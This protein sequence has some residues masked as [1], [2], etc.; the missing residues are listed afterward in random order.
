MRKILLTVAGLLAANVTAA[1]AQS[2]DAILD[3]DVSFFER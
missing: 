2:S 1:Q 3:P